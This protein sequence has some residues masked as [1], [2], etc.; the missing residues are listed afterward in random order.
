MERIHLILWCRHRCVAPCGRIKHFDLKH[1]V[2]LLEPSS[3]RHSVPRR[4][5]LRFQFSVNRQHVSDGRR[6]I[7]ARSCGLFRLVVHS[8]FLCCVC[9]NAAE[10]AILKRFTQMAPLA[11][12]LSARVFLL[13][14][15]FS[16]PESL[17]SRGLLSKNLCLDFVVHAEIVIFP[18]SLLQPRLH[19]RILTTSSH[20]SRF[21]WHPRAD[22]SPLRPLRFSPPPPCPIE[23]LLTV[24]FFRE[25]RDPRPHNPALPSCLLE[26][27]RLS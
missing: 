24:Q 8:P 3:C 19:S 9:W 1:R 11:E 4:L 25:R 22:R 23:A 15:F 26:P 14:R 27:A 10:S 16:Q 20:G 13:G 21:F 18:C 7:G 17:Q 5:K 12:S 6:Y 2:G